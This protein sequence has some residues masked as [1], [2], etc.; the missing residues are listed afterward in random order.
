MKPLAASLGLTLALSP[1]LTA[2]DG[3]PPAATLG[4]PGRSARPMVRGQSP[5]LPKPAVPSAPVPP[6]AA[7]IQFG[8]PPTVP[9]APMTTYSGVPAAPFV[10]YGAGAH[11]PAIAAPS[12]AE[13]LSRP[14]W[15]VSGE[16]LMWW[17]KTADIPVLASTGPAESDGIWGRGGVPIYGGGSAVP[18]LRAGFRVRAGT[19]F[20]DERKWGLDA[21]FFFLG[22]RGR[23]FSR[24]SYGDQVLARPFFDN[25]NGRESSEVIA[26]PG[27][28][29]G[30]I[31]IKTD[32]FLWGAELNAKR[33]LWETCCDGKM[34]SGTLL[35]GYRY[36][37][38]RERLEVAER[39]EGLPTGTF[40][41]ESGFI[42]DSF[43]TSNQF[44]GGQIGLAWHRGVGRW[45]FDAT[46]KIAL[47][48]MNQQV[49]TFGFFPADWPAV[50]AGERSRRIIDDEL[51]H[52]HVQPLA[53]GVHPGSDVER[54]LR[55]D[56][57][58]AGVRGL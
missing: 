46:P 49:Q 8:G 19:W 14:R 7:T 12:Y 35:F 37:D 55:R 27:Q 15:E 50:V 25:E 36:L 5:E 3:A 11:Y 42:I 38:L 13:Q 18:S 54:R 23:N 56:A 1:I 31:S 21:S 22:D 29:R 30:G 43:R 17:T 45:H 28:S 4:V 16:Y 9:A 48:S 34:S 33:R 58:P 52:R 6:P 51:E 24:F 47:G 39:F 32:S 2:Q 26:S 44:N 20:D 53:G 40:P 57:A 10:D 41:N